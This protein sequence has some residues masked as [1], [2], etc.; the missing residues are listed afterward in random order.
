MICKA[1]FAKQKRTAE[2][3]FTA[4]RDIT[5]YRFIYYNGLRPRECFNA[6][7][8]YLN[9]QE[10]TFF[11]PAIANKQRNQDKIPLPKFL[12][13]ELRKYLKLRNKYY[14]NSSYLFPSTKSEK[15]IDRG[16][17]IRQFRKAVKDAGLLELSYIDKQGFPRYNITLYSLRHSYGTIVYTKTKDIRKTAL[18]LRH[19]DFWCRST[20]IYIHTA[21]RLAQKELVNQIFTP[22]KVKVFLYHQLSR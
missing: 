15:T 22:K 19:R 8:S 13:P 3:I 7:I 14:P 18:L 1:R 10:E 9:F 12:M 20:L 5:M 16:T 21:E 17:I 11:I 4:I 6:K 2:T